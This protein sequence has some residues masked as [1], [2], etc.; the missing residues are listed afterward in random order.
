MER[1]HHERHA[2]TPA[3]QVASRGISRSP[4]Q[5]RRRSRRGWHRAVAARSSLACAHAVHSSSAPCT[6][7]RHAHTRK[8]RELFVSEKERTRV[9]GFAGLRD[10]SADIHMHRHQC[11]R[12][13]NMQCGTAKPSA[14][15]ML[16]TDHYSAASTGRGLC[17]GRRLSRQHFKTPMLQH[18]NKGG[19]KVVRTN[20]EVGVGNMAVMNTPGSDTRGRIARNIFP[21]G[22]CQPE[23]SIINTVEFKRLHYGRETCLHPAPAGTGCQTHL[24]AQGL[25]PF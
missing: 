21:N 5:P 8:R 18:A 17:A 16:S 4:R 6:A 13:R 22:C 3:K 19:N 24:N 2:C 12:C 15:N 7:A 20:V 10:V 1:K 11:D 25:A 14:A 9:A 23:S